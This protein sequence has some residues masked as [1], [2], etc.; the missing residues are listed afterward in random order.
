MPKARYIEWVAIFQ[1]VLLNAVNALLAINEPEIAVSSRV[2][3]KKAS[4]FIQDNG[5]GVNLKVA[6][7]LF[8]PFERQVKL[9][10]DM[11]QLGVGGSG[12]GLT[13]VRMIAENIG[14]L[15]SFGDPDEGFNT[16]FIL[17]WR[18]LSE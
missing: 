7:Q 10:S 13:I 8:E 15:V 6:E 16:S 12:L 3:G 11:R 17:T 14:C 9:S 4:L 2:S 18:E 5:I 1:N